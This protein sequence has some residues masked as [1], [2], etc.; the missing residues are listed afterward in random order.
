[1]FIT[2]SFS[3]ALSLD[4]KRSLEMNIRTHFGAVAGPSVFA[5]EVTLRIIETFVAIIKHVESSA[6]RVIHV[7]LSITRVTVVLII[8]CGN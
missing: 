5:G 2:F 1:M 4:V 8:D 3:L 6:R 7:V